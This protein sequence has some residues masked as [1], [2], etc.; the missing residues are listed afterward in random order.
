MRK[1]EVLEGAIRAVLSGGSRVKEANDF[2]Y[3]FVE[4]A[5]A[6]EPSLALFQN[7]DDDVRFF[8]SNIIYS[9][10]KKH[11]A[12]QLNAAQQDEIYRFLISVVEN[13]AQ[14]NASSEVRGSSQFRAFLNRVI[15]SL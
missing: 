12:T 4:L 9:K 8:A 2:I 14:Y 15:L 5:E 10:V 7:P 3:S 1:E 13:P 6:F 11:W